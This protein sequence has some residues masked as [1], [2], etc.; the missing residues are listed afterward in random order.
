MLVACDGCL[1]NVVV[2]LYL[3]VVVV[4]NMA[5]GAWCGMAEPVGSFW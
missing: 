1:V 5:L 3:P 2:L 4:A